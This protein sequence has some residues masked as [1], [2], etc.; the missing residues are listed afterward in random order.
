MEQQYEVMQGQRSR[1][2]SS[3]VCTIVQYTAVKAIAVSYG[4]PPTLTLSN[5]ETLE[6]IDTKFCTLD[7]VGD[8]SGCAKNRTIGCTAAPH[9]YAKYNVLCAFLFVFC[10]VFF[11]AY[12]G[13]RTARARVAQRSMAQKTCFPCRNAFWGPVDDVSL[14]GVENTKNCQIGISSVTKILNNELR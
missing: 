9:T 8:I 10:F 3:P 6:P 11:N 13:S 1:M 5:S 7:Y 12:S 14:K 4:R 2:T